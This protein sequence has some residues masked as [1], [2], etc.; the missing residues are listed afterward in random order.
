LGTETGPDTQ[1]LG[2]MLWR[3]LHPSQ[4]VNPAPRFISG[5]AIPIHSAAMVPEYLP[6]PEP[7]NE[8][9]GSQPLWD[10]SESDAEMGSNSGE[11]DQYE[12][13]DKEEEIPNMSRHSDK[14]KTCVAEALA[15]LDHGAP[16]ATVPDPEAPITI[17]TP[18]N[19]GWWR[20]IIFNIA[21]RDPVKKRK[22]K[23]GKK[24]EAQEEG[25][26]KDEIKLKAEFWDELLPWASNIW[27]MR[28]PKTE[29]TRQTTW[30]CRYSPKKPVPR[31]GNNVRAKVRRLY[32]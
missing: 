20:E 27:L 11:D 9:G 5:P 32:G 21:L 8:V 1:S 4:A 16:A 19:L 22:V 28:W 6:L 13:E 18:E 23:K 25:P 15:T 7:T 12:I 10:A 31:Q 14:F 3:D 24:A 17:W 29:E 30:P 26:K 2:E